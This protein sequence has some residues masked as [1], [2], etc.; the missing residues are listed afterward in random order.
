MSIHVHKLFSIPG[1]WFPPY[2]P[3]SQVHG[4]TKGMSLRQYE[5]E[6]RGRGRER[7]GERE[8]WGE[9]NSFSGGG[10]GAPDSLL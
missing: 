8:R 4:L 3:S 6:S 1:L 2:E 10:R 9:S 5:E 7:D